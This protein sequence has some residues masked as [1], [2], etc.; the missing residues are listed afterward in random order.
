[1]A[2]IKWRDSYNTGVEQMDQEH[3][4]LVELI[5]V[6]HTAIRDG[7]E[8]EKVEEALGTIT[9]YTIDHFANE[10]KLMSTHDYP[11][12]ALHIS[13]HEKLKEDAG[14]FKQQLEE[15]FPDGTQEFYRFLREWL[16]NHILDDDKKFAE[17]L[18]T[19][20]ED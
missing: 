1:M 5:E 16:I 8:K 14:K 2:I 19:Q 11:D 4:Q 13:E 12:A 9:Q 20:K 10:E 17:F 18:I 7:A 3:R 15:S 6:M